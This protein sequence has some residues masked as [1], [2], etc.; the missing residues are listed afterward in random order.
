MDNLWI[1]L[2]AVGTVLA[3][4]TYVFRVANGRFISGKRKDNFKQYDYRDGKD[5]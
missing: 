5:D 4:L 2:L 1:V 3:T